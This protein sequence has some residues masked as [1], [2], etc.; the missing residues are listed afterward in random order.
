[1]GVF[2][3]SFNE[4]LG[5]TIN[6]FWWY[7]LFFNRGLCPP[8]FLGSWAMVASYLCSR[9]RIFD[10]IVLKEY[11]FKIEGGPHLFNHGYMKRKMAFLL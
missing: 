9:F 8:T 10:R 3:G 6:I 5:L 11:D 7:K 2:L 4:V 1:M